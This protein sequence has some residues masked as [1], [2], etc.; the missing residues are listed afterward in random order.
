MLS[1]AVAVFLVTLFF[2][3]N[4]KGYDFSNHVSWLSG[5]PGIHFDK[6]GIAYTQ[7]DKNLLAG[8]T[9]S[10][11]G[12]SIQMV[13]QPESFKHN[14]FS[15]IL[16]LHD[17]RDPDQLLIGQWR[18]YIIVMNGD[19]YAHRRKTKRIYAQLASAPLEPV[20]FSITTGINGS[21]IYINGQAVQSDIGLTLSI[22][23]GNRPELIIGNSVYGTNSWQGE[24]FGLAIHNHELSPGAIASSFQTWSEEQQFSST[25][26]ERPVLLYLFD[27]KTGGSVINHAGGTFPLVIPSR[28]P[29]LKKHFL[30]G[31]IPESGLN[32]SFF[33]DAAINLAGFI[34]LGFFLSA[35]FLDLNGIFKKKAILFAVLFCFLTSLNIELL[36]AWMPSRS[37]QSLDLILNTFGALIGAIPLT[38]TL[39]FSRLK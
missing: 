35:V 2:G 17:G 29:L 5:R 11:D 19:D 25:G 23:D 4:P 33:M 6:Y 18:S 3:L 15:H 39:K 12:F 8:K 38:L 27:E 7:L 24:V 14:E 1:A 22:P 13:I 36:Q 16:S 31:I 21:S 32:R 20:F 34:P 28:L 30:T 10:Q 37:S 26:E 9:L